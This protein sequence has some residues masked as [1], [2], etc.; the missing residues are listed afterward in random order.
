MRIAIV[1][2]HLQRGGVTR[3]IEH[4]V[5]AL[6]LHK[7]FPVV[8]TGHAPADNRI[9]NYRV[10]PGLQYERVRPAIS[11]K[12]LA[13]DMI[14][15]A[16]EA[17]GGP[18]D[19]WHIHNHSLGKNLVLPGA[20][21]DLAERGY[22][23]LLHIHDFAEDGRAANYH[24]MLEKMACGKKTEMSRLLYPRAAHIHYAVLN[25]RDHTFLK[26]AGTESKS[27][28]HLPNAVGLGDIEKR[29][30]HG[31]QTSPPLWLYP[32]RAIRRKNLGEF[33]LWSAVVPGKNRFAATMGPENPRERS[34][35]KTWKRLAEELKLPVEFELS[36][37]TECSFIEL[38][39]QAHAL[40]T[41][42][43]AEGFGMAFL[44]PWLVDRPVCGRDLPEITKE[45]RE[46]GII[47]QSLYR[48]LD[49]PVAWLGLDRIADSAT[50]ARKR[51][52][53]F[54]GRSPSSD[55]TDQILDTW[56]QDNCIDFG[57]LDENMQADLLRTVVKKPGSAAELTPTQL[58]PPKNR[59]SAID[60]NHSIL[61][62]K[63]S[64]PEYGKRL[65]HLYE[66]L[67]AAGTE[68]LSS[69]NAD[70]LLDHF[71]APERLTLLRVD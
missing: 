10:I 28:H 8:L 59:S 42:S 4:S 14:E 32:T 60:G 64:L 51:Q 66:Q 7:I 61:A 17:L 40:V 2:Y 24:L 12:E 31:E 30:P 57:R 46:D 13:D 55:C 52:L 37:K 6:S 11:A 56:V 62:D 41:T 26:Y 15:A 70:I 45:F 65:M 47:L 68:P 1:H 5:K 20:I 49:M 23:I 34:R 71:L 43:V 39:Q 38:L 19:I 63:Y 48:R 36:S 35:Y 44:E 22:H 54:Y 27:L 16:V 53:Q 25:R 3:A 18:P 29:L 58:L 50:T 67:A 21:I 9:F 33:L 69:L